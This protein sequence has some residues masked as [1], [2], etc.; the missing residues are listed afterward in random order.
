MS[1]L[2]F[3][4]NHPSIVMECSA[5]SEAEITASGGILMSGATADSVLGATGMSGAMRFDLGASYDPLLDRSWQLSFETEW[6]NITTKATS[7][8]PS[9]HGGFN[10]STLAFFV[11][12]NRV[13]GDARPYGLLASQG[14]ISTMLMK[15]NNSNDPINATAI[16]RALAKARAAS[17]GGFARVTIAGSGG[18]QQIRINDVM[19][20]EG[21]TA[22][23]VSGGWRYIWFAC[24]P[25]FGATGNSPVLSGYHYRNIT[26]AYKPVSLQLHP[27]LTNIGAVGD[28]KIQQSQS[29]TL[30]TN[31]D[32]YH[33][34]IIFAMQNEFMKYGFYSNVDIDDTVGGSVVDDSSSNPIIDQIAPVLAKNPRIILYDA[35]TNDVSRA[36]PIEDVDTS[37]KGHITTMLNHPSVEYVI[38]ATTLT[39]S[40]NP[41]QDTQALRDRCDE[42]NALKAALPAWAI[43]QGFTG[44]VVVTKHFAR[45]G[46]H[47]PIVD[48]FQFENIHPGSYGK[49][50]H[51]AEF[52]E[53][54]VPLLGVIT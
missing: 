6:E 21:V 51:G 36:Q 31:V 50:E 22:G 5:L 32:P 54:I 37:M 44:R 52:A 48:F 38:M 24:A 17:N 47:T 53:N 1:I 25:S 16:G 45:F 11:S 34:S 40:A 28:S 23:V 27:L 35:G 42:I 14:S 49:W 19:L 33:S 29:D 41:A 13:L 2:K 4:S 10:H 26:L 3:G 46:G 8:N 30:A 9:D 7:G 39:L 18:N 20:Y 12:F 15:A 43:T